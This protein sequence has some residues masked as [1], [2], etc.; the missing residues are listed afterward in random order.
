[1]KIYL[2]DWVT[3]VTTLFTVLFI[4]CPTIERRLR[5]LSQAIDEKRKRRLPYRIITFLY[6]SMLK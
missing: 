1:M 3:V 6:G 5:F 4:D 2:Q